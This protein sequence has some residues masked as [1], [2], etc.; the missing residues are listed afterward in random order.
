VFV[1]QP[2]TSG[3]AGHISQIHL[4]FRYDLAKLFQRHGAAAQNQRNIARAI[5]YRRLQPDFRFV[6]L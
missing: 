6:T 5:H 2:G 3:C 1:F 4:R